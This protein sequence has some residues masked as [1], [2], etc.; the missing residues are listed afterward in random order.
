[1]ATTKAPRGR[2]RDPEVDRQVIRA[3]LSVIGEVGYDRMTMDAVAALA[4]VAKATVYR[5]WTS[6]SELVA[7][8]VRHYGRPRGGAPADTGA[9]RGDLFALVPNLLVFS[10]FDSTGVNVIAG[11]AQAARIRPELA[12]FLRHGIVSTLRHQSA[13]V[14]ERAIVR[15]EISPRARD[16]PLLHDIAPSILASRMLLTHEPID[17]EFRAEL[18]DN[19]LM[20]ILTSL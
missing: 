14:I 3:A 7:D 11:L 1:M 19:L 20:P 15:G 17:D 10:E 8:A 18:I 13:L 12:E 16:H 9:L 6:K 4:G 2:P 5:R